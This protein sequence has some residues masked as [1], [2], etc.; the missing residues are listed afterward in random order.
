MQYLSNAYRTKYFPMYRY[1]HNLFLP[2]DSTRDIDTPGILAA[3]HSEIISIYRDAF[4]EK[5]IYFQ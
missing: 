4:L 1:E 2:L 3:L 5:E